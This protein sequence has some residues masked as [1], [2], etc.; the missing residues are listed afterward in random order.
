MADVNGVDTKA[1]SEDTGAGSDVPFKPQ[2]VNDLNGLQE[3]LSI[4][5]GNEAAQTYAM[6]RWRDPDTLILWQQRSCV[7]VSIIEHDFFGRIACIVWA[8]NPDHVSVKKTLEMVEGWALDRRC[9]S[10]V[11][12]LDENGP[13]TRLKPYMRLTGLKPFRMVFSKKLG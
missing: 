5:A 8:Q 6:R 11:S 1:K 9:E 13:W 10:V 12:F 7:M 3:I 2:R 4:T